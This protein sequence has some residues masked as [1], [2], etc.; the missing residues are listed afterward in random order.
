MTLYE[1]LT[2]YTTLCRQSFMTCFL[3]SILDFHFL[4]VDLD[5]QTK[6]PAENNFTM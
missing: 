2:H 5:I 1:E 3:T 6:E 4:L